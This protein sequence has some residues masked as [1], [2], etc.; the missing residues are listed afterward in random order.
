MYVCTYMLYILQC[1]LIK[2]ET[3]KKLLLKKDLLL[4]T[5]YQFSSHDHRP[6]PFPN[7]HIHKCGFV[8]KVLSY[9]SWVYKIT[10]MRHEKDEEDSWKRLEWVSVAMLMSAASC[11]VPMHL[12]LVYRWNSFFLNSEFGCQCAVGLLQKQKR[13]VS[14]LQPITQHIFHICVLIFVVL[15]GQK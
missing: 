8:V 2:C 13:N 10:K 1:V 11:Q 4:G 3:F 7:F 15:S 6:M 14:F 5:S 12:R 9:L